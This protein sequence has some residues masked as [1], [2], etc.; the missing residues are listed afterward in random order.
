MTHRKPTR[1][2]TR[3]AG[4]MTKEER[5]RLSKGRH[6]NV[7]RFIEGQIA[8]YDTQHEADREYRRLWRIALK[9]VREAG[10]KK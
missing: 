5:A 4:K 1:I 8:F 3:L 2:R 10:G 9:A 7:L 6:R